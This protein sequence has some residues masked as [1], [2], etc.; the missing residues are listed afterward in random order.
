MAAECELGQL[1]WRAGAVFAKESLGFCVLLQNAPR[2]A[3][4]CF[5]DHN[6]ALV[7]DFKAF[8]F[9]EFFG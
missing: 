6:I 9:W 1:V 3:F 8:T 7:F 2:G 5:S 4:W